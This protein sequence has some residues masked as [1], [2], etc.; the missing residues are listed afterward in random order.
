MTYEEVLDLINARGLCK[1]KIVF[2]ERYFRITAFSTRT[3]LTYVFTYNYAG[4]QLSCEL[5]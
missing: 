2:K 4:V 1:Q 5:A 3:C